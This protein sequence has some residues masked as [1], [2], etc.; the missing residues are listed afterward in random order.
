MYPVARIAGTIPGASCYIIGPTRTAQSEI[1]WDNR[2]IHNYLP[3][4]WGAVPNTQEKRLRLNNGSFI[5]IEGADN[6]DAARG[7]E[8]HIFVWDEYKDQNPLSMENCYP[9]VLPHDAVWIV[10]GTPPT[11]KSSHYWIKEQEIIKDP[12][13]AFFHWTAW[14]NPFLPGGKEYLQGEKE[15]YYAR[16]DGDLW[17][18]EYE[19][20]YVF[21]ASRKVLPNFTDKNKRPRSV[22]LSM[23]ERDKKRFKWITLIDP[24][25]ATCFAVL[26]LGYNPYTNQ[27]FW[28]DEIYSTDRNANSAREMWPEIERKQQQ[29]G[30]FKWV[31]VYDCAA[32]SFAVEVRAI[33]RD[34]GRKV[35]IVPCVKEKDDEENYFRTVNSSFAAEGQSY[36]A[37]ECVN[38][39]EEM[40]NYETDELDRYPDKDNH[41]LDLARYG[42]KYLNFLSIMKQIDVRRVD[43][44]PKADTIHDLQ[45]REDE[46]GNAVGFGGFEANFSI[47]DM[48]I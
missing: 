18:I 48:E 25:Y 20:E 14:D 24:G 6:P 47:G 39:I 1:I 46:K 13:W 40:E 22:I 31:S 17:E 26:F 45:R 8:G 41:T 10:L 28:L 23:I 44:F 37:E 38:F 11:K 27:L 12:D 42:L 30:D 29:L 9:N 35:N 21:N 3:R 15:K 5:K 32:L 4:E 16:G 34:E 33:C 19:A 43:T 36:V 7:W 2:R